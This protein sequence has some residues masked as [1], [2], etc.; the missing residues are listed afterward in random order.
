LH[1]LHHITSSALFSL[2]VVLAAVIAAPPA[3]G[4]TQPQTQPET[5]QPQAQQQTQPEAQQPQPQP[6][7]PAHA[8]AQ[9]DPE[10]VEI[11]ERECRERLQT[12]EA[13]AVMPQTEE[14]LLPQGDLNTIREAALAFARAGHQQ[15]CEEV[16]GE[17]QTLLQQRREV[18][19]RDLELERVRQAIPVTQL[20]FTVTTTELVGSDV[21]NHELETIG[22]LEDLILTERDGRYALIR[23]GG[24]LGIGRNYTPVALDRLRMTEDGQ[25]LVVHVTEEQFAEAP[26]IDPDDIA[27]V[28]AWS[29]MV[30]QWWEANVGPRPDADQ[31]TQPQTAQP[32]TA[33]EQPAPEQQQE[34]QPEQ[35][36][37]RR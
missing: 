33:P 26:E 5:Q 32:Q 28:E 16:A 9:P 27:Q 21:V 10:Q 24:F 1:D 19:E 4:Q 29:A 35:Q 7:A 23:H 6:G 18:V 13:E 22:R 2:M 34:Q 17:L 15:G 31:A 11:A 36:Q 30:D 14:L 37:E 25:L 20:P 8:R 12:V 3:Y